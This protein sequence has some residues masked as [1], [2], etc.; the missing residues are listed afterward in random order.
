MDLRALRSGRACYSP[1]TSLIGLENEAARRRHFL[2]SP[3]LEMPFAE[4][5]LLFHEIAHLWSL[6]MTLLGCVFSAAAARAW[7][8]WDDGKGGKPSIPPR[9]LH[10]LGVCLPILEGLALYAELDY[11]ADEDV[12]PI[13]SPV[14]KV[15]S[16]SKLGRPGSLR[17][18]EFFRHVRLARLYNHDHQLLRLLVY[19]QQRDEREHAYLT[20]YL[21]VKAVA[22]YLARQC[23]GLAAPA[24]MLPFLIRAL[25][26]HPVFLASQVTDLSTA[27]ILQAL[28]DRILAL[29]PNLLQKVAKWV[30][31]NKR[32]DVVSQFD[33]LDLSASLANNAP[34]FSHGRLPQHAVFDGLYR[35]PTMA[36]FR[37]ANSNYLVA[38]DRGRLT[39]VDR[40]EG[41]P[42]ITLRTRSGT[43][44]HT[45]HSAHQFDNSAVAAQVHAAVLSGLQSAIG[46]T[47]TAA[48]YVNLATGDPGMAFWKDEEPLA[49]SPYSL[50]FPDT[51]PLSPH[52]RLRFA[53]R[54]G[55]R[56]K[57]TTAAA[58]EASRWHLSQLTSS[59][60][61]RERLIRGK[62]SAIALG[63]WNPE[64]R[65]W[66]MPHP[67]DGLAPFPPQLAAE[68]DPHWD[69]PGFPQRESIA[70]L[71]PQL[72]STAP[73]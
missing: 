41:I 49:L 52:R 50:R 34:S 28:H 27:A 10:L 38:F 68:I 5:S 13:H 44:R 9:T 66:C 61:L 63:R 8:A 53:A 18:T 15:L 60:N 33:F 2:A 69:M 14:L 22:R 39:A 4:Y 58:L 20:G 72:R 42:A 36:M 64:L 26:D 1:F 47:V 70:S 16:L 3:I 45:I 65:E 19:E 21:Y 30:K 71:M 37:M 11:F 12:D 32:G 51:I 35:D 57:L 31:R 29:A 23:P 7:D 55:R 59:E 56:S 46:S 40:D 43:R 25:C 54:L 17:A 6:R 48:L 67:L 62:L 73:A 24:I